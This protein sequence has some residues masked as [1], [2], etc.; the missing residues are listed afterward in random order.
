M[1]GEDEAPF[2]PLAQLHHSAEVTGAD[3]CLRRPIIA[4]A[5]LDRSVRIWNY[6]DKCAIELTLMLCPAL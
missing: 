5:S 6:L 1:Q 2:L 3:T 4:T